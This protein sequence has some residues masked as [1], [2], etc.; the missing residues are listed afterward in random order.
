MNNY[1]E[2]LKK[3]SV[4]V[5]KDYVQPLYLHVL[6]G[7]FVNN[8]PGFNLNRFIN[9]T[10]YALDN[11]T[12]KEIIYMYNCG[13][14]REAITASWLGGIGRFSQHLKKIENLLLPSKN[15][16]AG[17]FHCFALARFNVTDSVRIL[18]SYLDTYLP[19]GTQEYDQLWAIGALW[20]LDQRNGTN[21]AEVYLKNPENWK[22]TSYDKVIGVKNPERG[23]LHFQKVME[24]VDQ[25]FEE[26]VIY[27]T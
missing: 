23:I 2:E 20:W 4:I 27:G 24:F 14:W 18:R 8:L 6:G 5:Q 1:I 7:N 12:D 17:Q 22:V 11:I 26:T 19:V 13:D 15:C 21:Y 3:R 10:R 9:S 25:Y 16:Y